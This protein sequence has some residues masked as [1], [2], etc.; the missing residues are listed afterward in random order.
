MAWRNYKAGNK[1]HAK[2]IE[3]DGEIFDSKREA[4]RYIE[5]QYLQRAGKISGLQR[6]KKFV[7]IPAQYEPESTG[8]RGGKIKG[9]LL[10]REVAYYADFVYFDEEEKDFVIED[11][12]GVR[13]KDY[14]IKRKL[15]LW[16]NGYQIKEI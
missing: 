8:P 2:K 9:K 3:V 7:L 13:T 10:E 16:L 14:I 5:L 15:M 12:K 6:Q 4:A 1:Y 11:T